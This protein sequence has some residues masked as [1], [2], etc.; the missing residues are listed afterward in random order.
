M[1]LRGIVAGLVVVLGACGS[2]PSASAGQSSS[3]K[4]FTETAVATFDAPWAMAFLPGSGVPMTNMALVTEKLGH[5]WL[6]DVATGRKQEVAGVPEVH[7]EGQG[8][9]ARE[10]KALVGKFRKHFADDADHRR[11]VVDQKQT[12]LIG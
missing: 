12:R 11:I 4:P 8:G 6:V 7:A 5:L 2:A 10:S 3:E 9:L 1:N